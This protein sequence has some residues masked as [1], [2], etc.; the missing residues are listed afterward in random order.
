MRRDINAYSPTI[1]G[2]HRESI[3]GLVKIRRK[4]YRSAFTLP[5]NQLDAGSFF[6]QRVQ[7]GR[8]GPAPGRQQKARTG[9]LCFIESSDN[10]LAVPRET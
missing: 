3:R 5:V 8:S 7:V 2:D 4:R 1:D 9:P 6:S 10:S